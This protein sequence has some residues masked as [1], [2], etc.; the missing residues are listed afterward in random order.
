MNARFTYAHLGRRVYAI[1]LSFLFCLVAAAQQSVVS[2]SVKAA[3]DGSPLS[4]I[5]VMIKGSNNGTVTDGAGRFQLKHAGTTATLVI[6]GQGFLSREVGASGTTSVDVQLEENVQK[7]EEVVVIGYG[8]QKKKD[9]TGAISTVSSKALREVPV[10]SPGQA[11]QGR[12]AGLVATTS[13]YSPG[14]DVSIRIRGNRSFAAGNDPLFVVDGIPITGGLNDINPNDIESMDVLKDASATAI[15]GSRG[16]NGVVIITTRRGKSGAPVVSYDA[17]YGVVKPLGKVQV[18]NGKEFAEYKR[19]SRRNSGK[20]IDS[21]PVGSDQKIFEPVE[22]QSLAQNRYTDYPGAMLV[23]GAQQS[24]QVGVSGGN[25]LTRY[26]MSFGYFDDKGILPI[27][28]FTRYTMRINLDQSLG[29]RVKVGASILGTYSTRNGANVNAYDDA[30]QENPLGVPYDSLGKL[31]FLPTNDGLR[32]NPLSELVPGAQI[33]LNKRFRL[34]SSLYGEVELAKGLKYRLN[35][36]PDLIQNRNGRFIGRFTNERRLGDPTAATSEDFVFNYTLEN[37]LTYNR[38][39]RSKHRLDFTG[40]YSVQS[41][42]QDGTNSSVRGVAIEDMEFYNTGTAPIINGVGSFYEKWDILSYMARVNYGFDS[43]FLLTLTGRA[44]GSSRFA[45][46]NKWGFFPS[47]ALGWNISNEGFLQNSTWI[48][49]LKLRAS[50]GTTGNT[51]INP[52]QTLGGLERTSYAFDNNGAYGYRPG[53]I[54]NPNLKWETTASLNLGLD[55]GLFQNRVAGSLELY[56]QNTSDLLMPRQL[57][58]TSG[59]GNILENVGATRNTGLEFTLNTVNI[60]SRRSN[61]FEWTTD[62]NLA[63]NKEE[64]VELY[65]GKNNDVGNRWF[66]GY[67]IRVIYDYEKIGIWQTGDKDLAT[68]YAQK[69]GQ[70]RVKDQNNDGK[71]NADD[72]VILGSDVP[73][74]TGGMTN[75]FSYRG[76][77][78]SVFVF[79]R[80]GSKIT[81]GF[82]DNAWMQLQGRYNNLKVD[83]WTP[84]NPTNKY[85]RPDENSEIPIYRSTLRYFD[86]S[87]FKVRN[88]NLGY[89]FSDALAQKIRAKSVRIYC[90][91]QQPL[92]LAPYRSKEK[93]IDPEYPT[94]NTPATTMYSFG[95][96]TRF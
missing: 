56:Q 60:A 2:G 34:F 86:G 74:L 79:A 14:S 11:L 37:I 6:T 53:I 87:F 19:E 83:Y 77:D 31:I 49:N 91:I 58:F 21:D 38:T 12:V 22:L 16:A 5:S 45:P 64:I 70:I 61:G 68:A 24:H 26:N 80:L 40:L 50:Y 89:T 44:D 29:K 13:G 3:K 62:I 88:I 63:H 92:I 28:R 84:N 57:P 17:Y 18:F 36:G 48:T 66:I 20:Y 1:A 94:V 47:V 73:K 8:Q 67:P 78:L 46:S 96:N 32:S 27:Q 69:P 55:F 23:N 90:S 41:R 82:H 51:G 33:D 52:Y 72:N 75:R 39:F 43:R 81:S 71:I 76:F 35:F 42:T 15:Y 7:M 4:G 93:G 59:F 65:G 10:N 25:D 95:I 30:L 54:P 9:V 85:P